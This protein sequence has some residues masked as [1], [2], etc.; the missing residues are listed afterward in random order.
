MDYQQNI[1]GRPRV[2]TTGACAIRLVTSMLAHT[3]LGANLRT[4]NSLSAT[5]SVGLSRNNRR[6]IRRL[7]AMRFFSAQIG[8]I[9]AV[10]LAL[11]PGVVETI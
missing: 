10:I 4:V 8:R 9:T 11:N 2:M 5:S 3:C 7:P 6:R 1:C